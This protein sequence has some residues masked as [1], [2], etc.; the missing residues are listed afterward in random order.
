MADSAIT[1]RERSFLATLRSDRWWVEPLAVLAGLGAFIVYATWAAYQGNHYWIDGGATGFGGYLSPFYSPV[2]YTD[3][4]ATGSAPTYHSI[5]G[6]WPSWWP[7]WLPASP[8]FLILIFPLSFRFTCYYYRGAYYKAF[9]GTPP[10]CA[11]GSIPRRP[12]KYRGESYIMIFQNLH[13]YTLYLALLFIPILYADAVAA[14]FRGGE[15]GIG[16]GSLI[17]LIN[18]TLLALYTFGCHSWRHLIGGRKDCFSCAGMGKLRYGAYKKSTWLN[19]RH[20][21]FAWASL[22]F[23]GV[24]DFYIRLVSM[25]VITDLNTWG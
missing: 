12:K 10:A 7:A 6:A 21:L 9:T 14:F 25:G 24:T 3:L 19:Q 5:L 20:K 15:F 17:L 23:V 4:T 18:P 22:I 8:A 13:R 2:I 11:V 16:V 1:F